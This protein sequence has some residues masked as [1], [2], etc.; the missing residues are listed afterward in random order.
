MKR[1][2]LSA[3][4]GV[5][6]SSLAFGATEIRMTGMYVDHGLGVAGDHRL[7]NTCTTSTGLRY[8]CGLNASHLSFFADNQV[9]LELLYQ[10]A[11][12]ADNGVA[13]W[14][15]H[16]NG[17]NTFYWAAG[18]SATSLPWDNITSRPTINGVTVEGAVL[19]NEANYPAALL[20][21]TGNAATATALSANPAACPT[22]QYVSDTDADGTLTCGTPAGGSATGT[23]PHRVASR[24]SQGLIITNNTTDN[25]TKLDATFDYFP[26]YDNQYS[27]VLLSNGSFTVDI[28][29]TGVLGLDNG[30][31]SV[32]TWYYFWILGKADGSKTGVLS[33]SHV[34]PVLPSGWTHYGL[35]GAI[36]NGD[37]N[38]LRLTN[39]SDGGA[40]GA[41]WRTINGTTTRG[42]YVETD[43]STLI[44]P[45]AHTI[46]IELYMLAVTGQAGDTNFWVYGYPVGTASW[47]T[48]WAGSAV[49]ITAQ[50]SQNGDSL[51]GGGMVNLSTPQTFWYYL[52]DN[53]TPQGWISVWMFWI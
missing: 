25:V 42:T 20:R 46:N 19:D 21:T 11:L 1:F 48:G 10:F 43:L 28:D 23:T 6:I 9:S 33:A 35:A 45:I 40:H 4:L 8:Y 15:L 53:G 37:D 31:K 27:G 17:D 13:G 22:G 24:L 50:L 30:L 3:I 47:G 29:N 26:A 49:G 14:S 36:Y 12:A 52:K 39:I 7:G 34:A 16:S 51:G 18:G 32:S 44:P 41:F 5:L 2:L 38:N